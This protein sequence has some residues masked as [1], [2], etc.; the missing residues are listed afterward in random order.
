MT[1]NA[2]RATHE[3][4]A[5]LRGTGLSE[6]ARVGGSRTDRETRRGEHGWI[7]ETTIRTVVEIKTPDRREDVIAAIQESALL[8][9]IQAIHRLDQDDSRARYCAIA[10]VRSAS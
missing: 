1:L 10:I 8:P 7:T 4:R 2:W 3:T 5:F 6:H 9:D